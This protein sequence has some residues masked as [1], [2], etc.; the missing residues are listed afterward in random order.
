[1]L[2]LIIALLV[3][4]FNFGLCYAAN[5]IKLTVQTSSSEVAAI[6]LTYDGHKAGG[7]GKYYSSSGFKAGFFY[8]FG[9]CS[10]YFS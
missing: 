5:T 9:Y 4:N 8:H 1:M 2:R 6:G 7:L 3:I 10:F